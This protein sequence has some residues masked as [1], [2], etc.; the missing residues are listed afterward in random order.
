MFGVQWHP[1]V[2][3]SDFGQRVLENFLWNTD[4]WVRNQR[5]YKII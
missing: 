1:E 4:L 3:H 5:M 2:V